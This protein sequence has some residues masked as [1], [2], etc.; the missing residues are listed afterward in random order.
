MIDIKRLPPG[1][2]RM[3]PTPSGYLHAGNAFNFLLTERFARSTGSGLFLRID[4]L[5]EERVRMHYL[6]DIF[7]TLKWLDIQWDEGP[8]D[9]ED[10]V[11]RWSQHHRVSRY[12]A[13]ASLLEASGDLYPCDCSRSSLAGRSQR[14]EEHLCRNHPVDKPVMGSAM[15]LRIPVDCIVRIPLIGGGEEPVDLSA[16]MQDPVILQ[17]E[18]GRPAYQLTSLIDDLDTRITYII[19]GA[20]LLPSTACQ[21]YMAQRMGLVNYGRIRFHHHPLITGNDGKKLSK[22]AGST[23]L[24]SLRSVGT[25]PGLFR[26][27]VQDYIHSVGWMLNS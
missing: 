27:M 18:S 16:T 24:A 7:S 19:R 26:Q 2:T 25:D 10:L 15:R 5:D 8:T 17:R 6:E 14:R 20:D 9:A 3:A 23:S 13:M 1:R 12:L 11:S 4:D 21:L 22:S